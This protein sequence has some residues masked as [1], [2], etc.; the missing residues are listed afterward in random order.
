MQEQ[1]NTKEDISFSISP[2]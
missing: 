2:L 1:D